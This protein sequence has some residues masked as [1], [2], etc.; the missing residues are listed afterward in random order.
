[1]WVED[2][3]DIM[4]S[5]SASG[6]LVWVQELLDHLLIL[7]PGHPVQILKYSRFKKGERMLTF[8]DPMNGMFKMEPRTGI[9]LKDIGS[10]WAQWAG[11]EE[12]WA[13][14]K[15]FW[16]VLL[17]YLRKLMATGKKPLKRTTNPYNSTH[18]PGGV[19]DSAHHYFNHCLQQLLIDYTM[20]YQWEAIPKAPPKFHRKM[21]RFP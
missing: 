20:S 16:R 5:S 4:R 15:V 14:K 11:I 9:L 7:I 3:V 19:L 1:M 17:R 18:M 12:R 10:Y 6:D 21:Q 13:L 8:T 2:N